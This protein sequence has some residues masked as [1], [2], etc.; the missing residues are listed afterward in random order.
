M[1][2]LFATIGDALEE[3]GE[4][5]IAGGEEDYY[6]V[7]TEQDGKYYRSVAVTDEQYRELLRA[8]SE[9]DI[10]RRE[11]AFDAMDEYGYKNKDE[12]VTECNLEFACNERLP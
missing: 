12:I 4:N 1:E 7:V 6:A 9:A 11:T 10:D 8:T 3:A 5:P 2:P